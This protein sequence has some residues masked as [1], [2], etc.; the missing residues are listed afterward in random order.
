MFFKNYNLVKRV[1]IVVF[2]FLQTRGCILFILEAEEN[3]VS[4]FLN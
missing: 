1:G 2:L 3:I 4:Y